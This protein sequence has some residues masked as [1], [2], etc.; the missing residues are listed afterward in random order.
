MK[1]DYEDLNAEII[2]EFDILDSNTLIEFI[3]SNF[4]I[5]E[6][7]TVNVR[8]IKELNKFI[9][10]NESKNL[11]F[12]DAEFLLNESPKLKKTISIVKNNKDLNTIFT[13]SENEKFKKLYISL[14]DVLNNQENKSENDTKSYE[15]DSDISYDMYDRKNKTVSED[16]F[17]YYLKEI[18]KI[19]LLSAT[20]EKILTNEINEGNEYAK[21]EFCEANLRLVVSIAKR[22]LG[23][24]LDI[25]DL[26]NEGNIGL[27]KAVNKFDPDKGYKFSTY[28]TFW[29]KQAIIRALAEQTRTVRLP[30]HV[31]EKVRSMRSIQR[32][33]FEINGV[34]IEDDEL[35]DAMGLS[36]E[37]ITDLKNI[38]RDIVSLNIPVGEDKDESLMDIIVSDDRFEDD[39]VNK[40]FSEEFM[41]IFNKVKLS[42]RERE[43][44]LSRVGYFNGSPL[45][46]E[47][48]GKKYKITR[49]RVR[50]IEANAL[51]K[52]R[53]NQE[54]IKFGENYYFDDDQAYK[55][56][57]NDS[58]NKNTRKIDEQFVKEYIKK[59]EKKY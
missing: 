40:I 7:L 36:I 18:G 24:G 17:K 46:L 11:D 21:K 22:Y 29:I 14:T 26:V 20:E 5:S 3:N 58:D 35:A 9:K 15:Y 57:L 51:R 53:L 49:E 54:I 19:P 52:L 55:R 48:I 47:E 30:V 59:F 34:N 4:E 42:E 31:S 1:N 45:T 50:Q 25:L 13:N 44:I 37:K 43:V 28:A 56:K 2:R 33:F 39:V 38:S 8:N 16:L 10:Q 27:I 41:T 12:L 23:K 6:N 32:N